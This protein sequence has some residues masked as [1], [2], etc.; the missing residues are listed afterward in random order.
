MK[1][2]NNELPS[3]VYKY[4]TWCDQKHQRILTH[5]ELYYAPPSSFG[6][7]HECYLE[8]DYDSFNDKDIMDSC[9]YLASQIPNKSKN[10]I[11]NIAA[12]LFQN[13]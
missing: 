4:R 10:E 2:E 12:H 11:Q 5:N 7:H 3:V 9:Y 13:N 1:V 6:D 8:M